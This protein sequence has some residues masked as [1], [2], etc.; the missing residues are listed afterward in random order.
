MVS[1]RRRFN[2]RV[3][4]C[5]IILLLFVLFP[6][7][8]YAASGGG[9]APHLFSG[10]VEYLAKI[11]KY[12]LGFSALVSSASLVYQ[13]MNG[14]KEAISK[15]LIALF[16]FIAGFV[17][18]TKASDLA[19]SPDVTVAPGEEGYISQTVYSVL[20][21]FLYVVI[22][23]NTGRLA[24]KMFQGGEGSFHKFSFTIIVAV[25]GVIILKAVSASYQG[26]KF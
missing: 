13:M 14:R 12:L 26:V 15:T 18:I 6:D 4:Y 21:I 17:I 1:S 9:S 22:I 23:I 3:I 10:A 24:A 11:V 20:E 2:N 16:A 8:A 19:L 25:V 5:S 7:Y